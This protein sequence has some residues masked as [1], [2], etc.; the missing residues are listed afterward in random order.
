[1]GKIALVEDDLVLKEFIQLNL[2]LEGHEVICFENGKAI[3]EA[4]NVLGRVDLIILDNMLPGK[5]GVDVC[6]EIRKSYATPI[7]FLSAKS[8]TQDRIEGLRAGAND[9]LPKPFDLEE[10][11][12]RVQALLPKNKP[13]YIVGN[14]EVDFD[15]LVAKE[16][17][18]E[19]EYQLSKKEAALLKLFIQQENK[20][21]SRE[22]ILD[23]VW[24]EDAYPTSRTIDN[25]V[26][27]FRRIFEVDQK[28]PA[29]FHSIRGVGY[30]FTNKKN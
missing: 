2:E 3:F 9:Y 7:L 23:K 19:L 14:W 11:L 8:N 10:L 18:K 20:V 4:N 30:K 29:Y 5:S 13:Q 26:L 21:L 28:S 22:E 6:L 17:S 25:F 24:G 15:N 1:M 16:P 27:T 12:L